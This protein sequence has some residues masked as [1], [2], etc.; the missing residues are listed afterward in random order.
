MNKKNSFIL[1]S[2]FVLLALIFCNKNSFAQIPKELQNFIKTQNKIQSGYYKYKSVSM[3]DNDT[4]FSFD[5]IC[6]FIRTSNDLKY[7]LCSQTSEDTTFYC[8]S[9]QTLLIKYKYKE[10]FKYRNYQQSLESTEDEFLFFEYPNFKFLLTENRKITIIRIPPKVNKKN[11]RY[12]IINP[13]NEMFT[14]NTTELEFQRKTFNWV[15]REISGIFLK[16]EKGY[17]SI[18]VLESQFYD[19][20]H[21]DILD[22]I[23]FRYE[24]FRK[25]SDQQKVIE[26]NLKDSLWKENFLDSIMKIAVIKKDHSVETAHTNEEI[27]TFKY[28][29]T[30][31]L[32]LLSGDTLYSDTIKS[33]FLLIDMWYISCFPC[34]LAM[35]ELSKIDTLFDKSLVKFVSINVADKDS[36]KMMLVVNK[37]GFE[38]EILC[39]HDNRID[40]L[41]SQAMGNCYGHPQLYMVDMRTKQ[42]I[43]RSCGY[44]EGFTKEIEAILRKEE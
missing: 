16:T 26:Y 40:T 25:K 28:M 18:E 4:T 7:L 6:Y 42:V 23:T 20:I 11:I 2:S 39:T 44:F 22:T 32:P 37:I 19:Y 21:P 31:R 24:E 33:R 3:T 43:W 30:W 5:M 17:G 27:D 36:A 8:K 35:N 29:P 13:D 34:R 12:K 10:D 15:H 38:S 41:L 14:N 1:A 9:G